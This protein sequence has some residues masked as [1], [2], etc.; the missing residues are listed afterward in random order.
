MSYNVCNIL[1]YAARKHSPLPISVSLSLSDTVLTKLRIINIVISCSSKLLLTLLHKTT[2]WW[3]CGGD[4]APKKTCYLY[5]LLSAV[6]LTYPYLFFVSPWFV[7]KLSAVCSGILIIFG[8]QY[9][10][11]ASKYWKL[12]FNV[13]CIFNLSDKWCLGWLWT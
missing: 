7:T 1:W 9:L 10:V 3:K 6:C 8:K 11:N 2:F 12:N 13:N 5:L 4:T